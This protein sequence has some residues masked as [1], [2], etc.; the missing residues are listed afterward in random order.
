MNRIEDERIE[1]YFKHEA[2]IREW[3][4]IEEDALAF[5]HSFYLTVKAP[6]DQALR[7][8]F[9]DEVESFRV[10]NSKWPAIALRRPDG[11]PTGDSD[12]D[13]RLEWWRKNC[14]LT[15]KKCRWLGIRTNAERYLSSIVEER[16]EEY[17]RGRDWW[18]AYRYLSPAPTRFW[19]GDGLEEYRAFLVVSLVEAWRDLSP[20]VDT[21]VGYRP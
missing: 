13:V 19:E 14:L 1:F 10:D 16:P 5:S 21:A 3:A 18:P 6:L 2:Q 15:K 7:E 9:P 11:W 20:I 12:P 17:R 8:H 4:E